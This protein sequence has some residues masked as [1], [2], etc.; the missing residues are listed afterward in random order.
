M[1]S[2]QKAKEWI[3]P[4]H[5]KFKSEL[6]NSSSEWFIKNGFQVHS[7]MS[8][9]LNSI[10]NWRN[11][12]ILLEVAD[13]IENFKNESKK[14]GKPFPLHKYAQH[15][16]SSQAMV[17]NLI[18]PLITRNDL[19]PLTAILESN[20]IV[21]KFEKAQFE[22]EDRTVFNEDTGQPTSIDVVLFDKV[23]KPKIFI[24]S[25]LA[26]AEFG[27]C[28]VFTNGDC[29]GGN[30]INNLQ[31]CY[32]HFIG[33]KYWILIEKYGF[34]EKLKNEKICI[35]VNYYQFFREILLSI[36]KD[37]YFVFLSD[38]RSH[39][40]NCQNG[41]KVRGLIPL[42]TEFVPDKY[43]DRIVLVTIQEIVHSIRNTG[44]HNDWIN[45]FELKYGLKKQQMDNI[46]D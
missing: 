14:N 33:R 30:P 1:N 5:N 18:G 6:R 34:F 35:L 24:E 45:E 28:S 20:G 25:K 43:R 7:K 39:V 42:L 11:N 37:G 40:F 15:G 2:R 32:L 46:P 38:E 36:D 31:E 26:E 8:S 16:L 10:E 19:S 17:F 41:G 44:R 13:Y 22:F 27:G 21:E 9:C 12:I 29:A 3:Y 4:R 23:N